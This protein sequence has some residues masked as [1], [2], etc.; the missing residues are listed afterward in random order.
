[1]PRRA[2][3]LGALASAEAKRLALTL[4]R[5]GPG[6]ASY[7]LLR[8][9][10]RR[11][12]GPDPESG[13]LSPASTGDYELTLSGDSDFT[14]PIIREGCPYQL[15]RPGLQAFAAPGGRGLRQLSRR[16]RSRWRRHHGL[17]RERGLHW[18]PLAL[19]AHPM[20]RPAVLRGFRLPCQFLLPAFF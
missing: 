5:C 18:E 10:R 16:P 4:L 15:R 6:A 3:G 1:M 11:A 12:A 13:C 2:A 20:D 7:R 9:R 8:L 17:G 14:G 19:E